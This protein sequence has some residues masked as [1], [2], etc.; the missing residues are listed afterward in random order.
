[1]GLHRGDIVGVDLN[2]KQGHETGKVR[3]C[4]VLSDDVS[5]DVL[6]TV[7]VVPLST[8]L[9]EDA[10]PYRMRLVKRKGLKYDSDILINHI[11]T[12]SQSRVTSHIAKISD[13]EYAQ[14]VHNMCLLF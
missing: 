2:P 12:I 11:R 10:L 1:M 5:N 6:D 4:I 8:Q 13:D 3:P 9:I 14:I 7:I